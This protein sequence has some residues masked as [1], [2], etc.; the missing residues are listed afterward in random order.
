MGPGRLRRA[1][2]VGAPSVRARSWSPRRRAERQLATALECSQPVRNLLE[3]ALDALKR[4]PPA[5][6]CADDALRGDDH[7]IGHRAAFRCPNPRQKKA[8][9]EDGS[10]DC[11]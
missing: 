8:I 1:T 3:P 11:I 5:A 10:A 4:T 9:C 2:R 7:R 6:L